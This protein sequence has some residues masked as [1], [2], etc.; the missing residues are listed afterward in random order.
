MSVANPIRIAR[1]SYTG[2]T[3]RSISMT[4][5]PSWKAALA[6][7]F[8][9]PYFRE[10]AKFVRDEREK[11]LVY[12]PPNQLFSAFNATPFDEVKVVILGQDP[13]H[14]PGQA[15]G[16]SFSVLPGVRLPPSLKN[17]YKELEQD[18]GCRK[19]RHGHLLCWAA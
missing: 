13:Y 11:G 10:L 9:K 5:H 17:I 12:P 4:L 6:D 16:L 2:E 19:V 18:L 1:C 14:G 8:R 3:G 7:E 15:H